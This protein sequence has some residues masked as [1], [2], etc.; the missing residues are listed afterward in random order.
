MRRTVVAS[1]GA[2]STREGRVCLPGRSSLPRMPT[3]RRRRYL[4]RAF[5]AWSTCAR[6]IPQGWRRIWEKREWAASSSITGLA[7]LPA[8]SYWLLAFGRWHLARIVDPSSHSRA[9][10]LVFLPKLSAQGW[11]FIQNDESKE[12]EPHHQSVLEKRDAAEQQSLTE[13]Q[14]DYGHIHGVAHVPIESGD[15]QMLR[16]GDRRRRPQAL[17]GEAGEG[18]EQHGQPRGDHQ[19][20]HDA[21]RKKA[22]Q[23][24]SQAPAGEGPGNIGGESPR[25]DR[26][27]DRRAEQSQSTLHGSQR[28]TILRIANINALRR[29]CPR[30][31][32]RS[33]RHNLPDSD[34]GHPR[35]RRHSA[36]CVPH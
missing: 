17:D 29:R 19:T 11:L 21:Q 10:I 20:A 33:P 1:A 22:E 25:S 6:P 14:R 8:A 3:T 30:P 32:P 27:K 36:F 13:D 5:P 9:I 24:Q 31:W 4:S 23:R 26:Q 2:I 35:S 15:D 12:P 28:T 16:R 18:I 7:W 34:A